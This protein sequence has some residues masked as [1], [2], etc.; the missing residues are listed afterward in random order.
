[1]INLTDVKK[2]CRVR[3]PKVW[4]GFEGR[5]IQPD[6][7]GESQGKAENHPTLKGNLNEATLVR[8]IEQINLC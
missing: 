3:Q 1:M 7:D 6:Q 2:N 4:R 8:N 5:L